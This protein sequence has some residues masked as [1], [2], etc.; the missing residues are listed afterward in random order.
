MEKY[1][2]GIKQLF[3]KDSDGDRIIDTGI[4]YEIENLLKAGSKK[5]KAKTV[6][7]AYNQ[8]YLSEIVE[9]LDG[10]GLESIAFCPYARSIYKHSDDLYVDPEGYLKSKALL[11]SSFDP[12]DWIPS[13]SESEI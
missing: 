4:A 13:G 12:K 3:G 5:I 8:N 7:T 2:D 11:E 6:V 9:F 10:F 1:P